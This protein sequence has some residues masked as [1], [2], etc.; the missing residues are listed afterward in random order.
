M[1]QPKSGLFNA[2]VARMAAAQQERKSLKKERDD[3][4]R[5]PMPL[6]PSP[7]G[8]EPSSRPGSPQQGLTESQKRFLAEMESKAE[9]GGKRR[10]SKT[11]KKKTKKSKK[12]SRRRKL[13]G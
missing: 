8:S 9:N 12:V 4:V 5:R 11:S 6:T 1:S 10:R 2:R 13:H 3:E 7:M